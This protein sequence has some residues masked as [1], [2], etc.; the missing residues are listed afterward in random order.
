MIAPSIFSGAPASSILDPCPLLPFIMSADVPMPDGGA[1]RGLRSSRGL[2]PN[3]ATALSLLCSEALVLF[4]EAEGIASA[5]SR[6]RCSSSS[7]SEA[8]ELEEEEAEL[9]RRPEVA[10]FCTA[11]SCSCKADGSSR[12]ERVS[13]SVS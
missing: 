6:P 9:P 5:A 13:S 4:A 7:S 2:K 3:P 12:L 11:M 10:D 1:E 8:R